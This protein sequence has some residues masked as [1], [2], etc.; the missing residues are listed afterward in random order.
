MSSAHGVPIPPVA[1]AFIVL[2]LLLASE[3]GAGSAR[4]TSNAEVAAMSADERPDGTGGAA[5]EGARCDFGGSRDFTCRGG[6]ACCYGP[7]YEVTGYGSCRPE[8]PP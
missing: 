1:P 4:P 5:Q 3:C 2:A 7:E 6:L 8:C